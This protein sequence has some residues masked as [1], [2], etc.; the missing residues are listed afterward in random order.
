M[1][2]VAIFLIIPILRPW[3]FYNYYDKGESPNRFLFS[4]RAKRNHN[5]K[6]Y[7]KLNEK[8]DKGTIILGAI[9]FTNI[10]ARFHTHARALRGLPRDSVLKNLKSKD[11]SLAAFKNAPDSIRQDSAIQALPYQLK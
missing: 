6:I 9:H 3:A 7:K 5:L 4:N 8:V 10:N 2:L 1:S 11:V